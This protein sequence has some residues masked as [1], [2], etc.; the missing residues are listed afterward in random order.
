MA[1]DVTIEESPVGP[2]LRPATESELVILYLHGNTAGHEVPDTGLEL[3]EQLAVLTGATVVCP[4]YRRTFTR[5][6]IDIHAAYRYCRA[7]GSVAVVGE[8]L[9][10]ALGATLALQLRDAEAA[11]PL[12]V[13]L[14]SGL[15]DLS[16][17]TKSLLFNASGDPAFD[18]AGLR[19][20]VAEFASG[21]TLTD[22]LLSPLY[23]NL[24]GLPPLQLLV[25][26]NDPLLDDSLAFATRAAR[27]RVPV[28][29][30]VCPE[31]DSFR[32]QASTLVAGFIEARV[33][34]DQASTTSR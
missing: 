33:P 20:R 17:E 8:G 26:G 22:A 5:A 21:M 27:S 34:A 28:E 2:V 11:S 10:G 13:V 16:L 3:A 30:H 31:S 1:R 19:R 29:L 6:S 24:H 7:T 12:C 25:A 32:A 4:R 15:L 9:G 18:L 14:L 23:A